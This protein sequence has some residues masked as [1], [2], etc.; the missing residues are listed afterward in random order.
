M[1]D[2]QVRD[3]AVHDTGGMRTK[4]DLVGIDIQIACQIP[5]LT[6]HT[7]LWRQ[8]SGPCPLDDGM[9]DRTWHCV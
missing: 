1:Y 4:D 8:G 7:H 5:G 9:E 3:T 6:A 2:D